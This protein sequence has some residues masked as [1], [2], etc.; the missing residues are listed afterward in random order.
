MGE[1]KNHLKCIGCNIKGV[2]IIDA[3]VKTKAFQEVLV[4]N[5]EKNEINGVK[6]MTALATGLRT[7]KVWNLNIVA[8]GLEDIGANIL[9]EVLPQTQIRELNI[10]GNPNIKNVFSM[11]HKN[12]ITNVNGYKIKFKSNCNKKFTSDSSLYKYEEPK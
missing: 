1:L 5:F 9:I 12:N 3:L 7:A 4:M 6:M 8:N 11:F 10:E 2:S